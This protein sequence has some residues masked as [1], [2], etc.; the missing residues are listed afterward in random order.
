MIYEIQNTDYFMHYGVPGMRWGHR[1]QRISLGRRVG[2]NKQVVKQSTKQAGSNSQSERRKKNVKKALKI[3][4][5]VAGTALAAYG[6]YK[7]HKFIN[8]K[9]NK[10]QREKGEKAFN[11][12]METYKKVYVSNLGGG[13]SQ[14]R[15]YSS[16]GMGVHQGSTKDVQ[17]AKQYINTVNE[18][19]KKR[20]NDAYYREVNKKMNF[21][22]K[23]ANVAKYYANKRKK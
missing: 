8:T 1:K 10:I 16:R 22:Q 17:R 4:A 3:G 18:G 23:T 9:S 21:R 19:V 13:K 20:A 6:G 5:A 2:R 11:K 7:L 12:A 15:S 14:L